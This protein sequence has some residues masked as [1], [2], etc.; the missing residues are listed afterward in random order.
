MMIQKFNHPPTP[1]SPCSD[2]HLYF[3]M[4]NIFFRFPLGFIPT[5]SLSNPECVL[6]TAFVILCHKHFPECWCYKVTILCLRTTHWKV[7]FGGWDLSGR[8]FQ[9]GKIVQVTSL[10]KDSLLYSFPPPCPR[11]FLFAQLTWTGNIYSKVPRVTATHLV[12]LTS[13]TWLPLASIAVL[14]L[15][16]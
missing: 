8:F 10:I 1:F 6:L 16:C 15:T 14:F 12:I 13:K 5:E 11:F 9:M 4:N 7:L 2:Y 3:V